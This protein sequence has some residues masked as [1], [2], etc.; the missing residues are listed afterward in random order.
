M[1]NCSRRSFLKGLFSASIVAV[2]V[3][4]A[5]ATSGRYV[6]K[7]EKRF[8]PGEF[9]YVEYGKDIPIH[10]LNDKEIKSALV[11]EDII[12]DSSE[13]ALNKRVNFMKELMFSLY[14]ITDVVAFD[15]SVSGLLNFLTSIE[16]V[17]ESALVLYSFH[18]VG[19]GRLSEKCEIRYAQNRLAYHL[20]MNPIFKDWR[21]SYSDLQKKAIKLGSYEYVNSYGVKCILSKY[22]KEDVTLWDRYIN[23]PKSFPE[24]CFTDEERNKIL[25]LFDNP[26]HWLHRAAS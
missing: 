12:W 2:A 1:T 22:D 19:L 26:S 9:V 18:Q 24:F 5:F 17:L 3:P 7:L 25:K 8:K 20:M 4:K 21:F 23:D 13:E 10:V 11:A 16:S 15:K 14:E 6:V